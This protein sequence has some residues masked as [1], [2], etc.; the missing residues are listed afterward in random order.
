M[1][2]LRLDLL[3]GILRLDK[4]RILHALKPRLIEL[5]K[6]LSSMLKFQR[7]LALS[8]AH[9]EINHKLGI[10]MEALPDLFVVYCIEFNLL[11]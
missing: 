4:V 10:T 5:E 9:S 1:D 6:L 2:V 3:D 11:N 8:R 7:R